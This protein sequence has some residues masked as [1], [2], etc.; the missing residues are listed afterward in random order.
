MGISS[1]VS[2]VLPVAVGFATG[3]PAAKLGLQNQ[4]IIWNRKTFMDYAI[5]K[6]K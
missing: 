1:I 5:G 4:L 2:R 3:G 6:G